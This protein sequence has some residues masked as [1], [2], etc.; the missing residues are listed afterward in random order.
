MAARPT[1]KGLLQISAVQIAI[2]VYPATESAGSISFNQLHD[3]CQTR[4][5][6]KRWCPKCEREVPNAE[7]VKGFEFEKGRYVILLEEEL[8]AVQP[9]ST[10]VI[11]LVQFADAVELEPYAIDRSY[12]L[13]PD[14][15][16]AAEAF[17]V[18]RIA[19]RHRVGIGKLAIYG[20]EYLVAVRPTLVPA[21]AT[22]QSVLMLHT[23]HHAAELRSADTIDDLRTA[24][25]AP[26]GQVRLFQQL[27]AALV[28]PLD[29][30]DFA[31]QYQ[32]D[33]RA[34]IDA[35]IAGEEIVVAL[36]LATPAVVSL[37]DA[38]ER[39]LAAVSATKKHPAK[40]KAPP[41]FPPNREVREGDLP[42]RKRA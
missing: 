24:A 9:P 25:P 31:D 32:I 4:M 19:L 28:Q 37:R 16:T 13:A 39:S 2:K 26:V 29:L 3:E 5:Q 7:I 10:R 12:Y 40:A 6:Q 27:I 30:G 42:K 20:R 41:P 21:P 36:P 33:V 38:L 1:W 14:G 23:L 11:D 35:K 18:L 34:L 8:D 17:S 22:Y 15:P